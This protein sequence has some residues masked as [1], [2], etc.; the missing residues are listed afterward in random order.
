MNI[1]DVPVLILAGGKGTRV[2]HLLN[3]L[4]KPMFPVLGKPFL[5]YLIK[6][7][8]RLGFCK[9]YLSIGYQSNSI[10]EHFHEH[11]DIEF[12]VEKTPLGTGGAVLNA[13]KVINEES[14]IAVNGDTF[15][16]MDF[17][18]FL[19]FISDKNHSFIVLKKSTDIS[20]YGTVKF[21]SQ[22]LITNFD[23]KNTKVLVDNWINSG[24]YYFI[25][26]DLENLSL[27]QTCSLETE[28][29]PKMI[30]RNLLFAFTTDGNFI[31]IGTP[32]TLSKTEEFLKIN[33]LFV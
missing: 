33:N 6:Y 1:T 4:P 15:F 25:K 32:E 29:F 16:L 13:T 12:I 3:D 26:S 7:F 31:D 2:K 27:N 22:Y 24:L 23:E 21:N 14:F 5:E 19:D 18:K 11:K 8:K 20:R 17:E 28:V 9:F 10:E 30:S